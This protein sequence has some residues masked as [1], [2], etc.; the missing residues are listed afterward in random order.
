MYSLLSFLVLK[1][2][3]LTYFIRKTWIIRSLIAILKKSKTK[4]KTIILIF[5]KPFFI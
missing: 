1:Q 3:I 4:L 5:V 2:N